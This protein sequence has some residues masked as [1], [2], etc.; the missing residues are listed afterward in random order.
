ME[1][2]DITPAD[3]NSP[4]PL[5]AIMATKEDVERIQTLIE[6]CADG[7]EFNNFIE[8][9]CDTVEL[10]DE[11]AQEDWEEMKDIPEEVLREFDEI[12]SHVYRNA[13]LVEVALGPTLRIMHKYNREALQNAR[14]FEQDTT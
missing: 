2:D 8:H 13:S 1:Q 10:E 7:V 4:E 12:S 3:G 9:L 14:D 11:D 6:Y 5:Y